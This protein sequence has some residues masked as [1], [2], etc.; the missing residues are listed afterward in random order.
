MTGSAYLLSVNKN[1]ALRWRINAFK[2]TQ[3]GAFSAA[4]GTDNADKFTRFYGKGHI[5]KRSEAIILFRII[6]SQISYF[7]L[8]QSTHLPDIV[9]RMYFIINK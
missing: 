2:N 6:D 7:N 8:T 4:A 1:A 3:K 5:F 9:F